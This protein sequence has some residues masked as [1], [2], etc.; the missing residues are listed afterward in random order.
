MC[1]GYILKLEF[2][3]P[4][5]GQDMERGGQEEFLPDDFWIL[6]MSHWVIGYILYLPGEK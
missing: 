5:D 3:E 2:S 6:G 1:K 4:M